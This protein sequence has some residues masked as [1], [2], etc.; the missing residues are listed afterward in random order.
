MW[1]CVILR[2]FLFLDCGNLWCSKSLEISVV[3]RVPARVQ[4]SQLRVN[5]AFGTQT[6]QCQPVSTLH[7]IIGSLGVGPPLLNP[8]LLSPTLDAV[9]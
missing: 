4:M 3:L 9:Q 7:S 6:V 5:P 1:Y 8:P 2:V